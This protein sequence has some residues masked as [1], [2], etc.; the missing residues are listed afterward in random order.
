MA[1]PAGWTV[2][3]APETARFLLDIVP[4][5][6]TWTK[7]DKKS[8]CFPSPG[9]TWTDRNRVRC[10]IM[11]P[12]ERAHSALQFAQINNTN[13]LY[14][15]GGYRV[16]YPYPDTDDPSIVTM[17]YPTSKKFLDDMWFFNLDTGFWNQVTPLSKEKPGPRMSHQIVNFTLFFYY[18]S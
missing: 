5:E 12:S 15:H 11:W 9:N 1:A 2:P 6:V 14:L 3:E 13:V 16:D 10:K 18:F 7:Y 17:K 4:R 8:V